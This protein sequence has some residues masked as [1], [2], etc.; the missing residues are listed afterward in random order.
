MANYIARVELHAA[1]YQDYEQLH[2]NMAARGFDRTIV[3][4]DGNTYQLPTGTYVARN[5]TD[6]LTVAL[7]AARDA[8]EA[9]GRTSWVIVTDWA[10]ALWYL[11]A[12]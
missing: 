11:K 12:V 8:A 7:N 10:A 1:N 5:V 2:G 9:A 6:S 3:G 4:N